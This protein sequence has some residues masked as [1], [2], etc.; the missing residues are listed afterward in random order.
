MLVDKDRC[1]KKA[2]EDE[3]QVHADEPTA[4]KDPRWLEG[5][6]DDDEGD[7]DAADTVEL[8]TVSGPA[9]VGRGRLPVQRAST[10]PEQ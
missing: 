1:D 9:D 6:A 4:L 3:E 10:A 8:T 7:R 2:G 5:V